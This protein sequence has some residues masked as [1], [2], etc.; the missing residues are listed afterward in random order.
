[1]LNLY[2][3]QI[4]NG[5]GL[6]MIYF[7]IAVGLSV[8]MGLMGFANLA[9]G[10]FYAIGAYLTIVLAPHIGFGGAMVAS[11]LLVALIGIVVERGLFQRFYRSDPILSLLLT[12]GLA[13]VAEQSA[14]SR[15]I[16]QSMESL[17]RSGDGTASQMEITATIAG[18]LEN[19]SQTM[20]GALAGFKTG[21]VD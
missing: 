21:K 20:S 15:D 12:F 8:T 1:M 7:L 17:A 11:P 9:H 14:A 13:M 16:A 3:F 19:V 10:A 18:E 4:L 2:L 5:L 6:G